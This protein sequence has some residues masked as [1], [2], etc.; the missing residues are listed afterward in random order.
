MRFGLTAMGH[1]RDG[2]VIDKI[3]IEGEGEFFPPYPEGVVE[4]WNKVCHILPRAE[5]LLSIS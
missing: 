3:H 4:K 1:S 2:F 5:Q